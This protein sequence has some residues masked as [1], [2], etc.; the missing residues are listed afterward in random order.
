MTNKLQAYTV[1]YQ[2]QAIYSLK[3]LPGEE[4]LFFALKSLA[5]EYTLWDDSKM[6]ILFVLFPLHAC[7]VWTPSMMLLLMG[8]LDDGDGNRRPDRHNKSHCLSLFFFFLINIDDGKGNGEHGF[9]CKKF[10]LTFHTKK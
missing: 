6:M 4:H 10:T 7:L 9:K 2:V 3:I 5:G 8:Y 1:E